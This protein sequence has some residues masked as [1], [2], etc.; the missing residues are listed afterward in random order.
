MDVRSNIP[1][2]PGR[3]TYGTHGRRLQVRPRPSSRRSDG[4]VIDWKAQAAMAAKGIRFASLTHPAGISSTG[5]EMLDRLL[6]FDEPYRIPASTA[7]AI[8]YAWARN[9]SVITVGTSATGALEHAASGDG[10]VRSGAGIA[11]Q[12]LRAFVEA[13]LLRHVIKSWN[14]TITVHTNLATRSSSRQELK[15]VNSETT[16]LSW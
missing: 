10:I 2:F 16:N 5:D 11:T 1:I 14:T 3:S 12:L 15:T 8:A 7:I 9:A 13:N 4:F 6:P